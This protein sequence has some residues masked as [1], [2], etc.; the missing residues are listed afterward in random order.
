MG[1]LRDIVDE[2]SSVEVIEGDIRRHM[3]EIRPDIDTTVGN[4][5]RVISEFAFGMRERMLLAAEQTEA[6]LPAEVARLGTGSTRSDLG[7]VRDVPNR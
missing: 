4:W 6:L 7:P 2:Q 1:K 3:K 5:P